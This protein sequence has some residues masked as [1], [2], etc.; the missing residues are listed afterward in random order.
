MKVYTHNCKMYCTNN[1]MLW[2][3]IFLWFKNLNLFNFFLFLIHLSQ[4]YYHNQTQRKIKVKMVYIQCN[5]HFTIYIHACM[6][7]YIHICIHTYM[8]TCI[9]IQTYVVVQFYPWFNFDFPLFFSMLIC[10]N[11]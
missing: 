4:T 11:K 6:H 1:F 9:H 7:A 2:L 10:D 5:L 3:K 8:H